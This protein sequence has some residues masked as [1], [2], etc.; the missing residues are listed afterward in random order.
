MCLYMG[1]KGI[2]IKA[3]SVLLDK[4]EINMQFE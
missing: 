4:P 3:H 2:K 1:S